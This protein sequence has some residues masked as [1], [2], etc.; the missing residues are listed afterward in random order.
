MNLSILPQYRILSKVLSSF[1]SHHFMDSKS[2]TTESENR[3]FITRLPPTT[4]VYGA[5]SLVITLPAPITAPSP[6]VTPLL[7]IL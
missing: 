3:C 1:H 2:S 7:I 4:T 5:I 6:I